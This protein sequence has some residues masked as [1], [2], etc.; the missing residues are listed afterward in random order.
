[1]SVYPFAPHAPSWRFGA[2][3]IITAAFLSPV[4]GLLLAAG[5]AAASEHRKT[6]KFI[7]IISL[8]VGLG[9]LVTLVFFA[10][11]TIEVRSTLEAAGSGQFALAF[12]HAGVKQVLL[13]GL[14]L[15]VAVAGFR[16]AAGIQVKTPTPPLAYEEF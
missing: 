11:D 3:G 5:V 14:A 7:S 13:A 4:L 16:T 10:M 1:M 12:V 8:L 6:L 9:L 2:T 15:W